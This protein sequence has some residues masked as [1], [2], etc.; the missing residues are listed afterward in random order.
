MWAVY[1]EG[2][3][4]A[5]WFGITIIPQGGREGLLEGNTWERDTFT[6]SSHS[7]G[8]DELASIDLSFPA[9]L[10]SVQETT[11]RRVLYMN[12]QNKYYPN[13]Y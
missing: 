9:F 13:N 11:F 2:L 3:G 10:S 6:K 4:S 8:P 5:P 1:S 12:F 7:P